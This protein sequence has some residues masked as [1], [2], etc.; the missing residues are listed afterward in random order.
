M[1][2]RFYCSNV[3]LVVSIEIG[4]EFITLILLPESVSAPIHMSICYK[5]SEQIYLKIINKSLYY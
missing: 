5:Y 4:N 3:F 1:K 2:M